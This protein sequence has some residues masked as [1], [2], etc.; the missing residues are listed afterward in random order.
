MA[1]LCFGNLCLCHL[2]SLS[3]LKLRHHYS[4]LEISL[5][6]LTC[7]S[8]SSSSSPYLLC[9]LPIF[10]PHP[11]LRCFTLTKRHTPPPWPGKGTH[12]ALTHLH[13]HHRLPSLH[14]HLGLL[15]AGVWSPEIRTT[16]RPSGTF[17]PN[18]WFEKEE[19]YD[20]Y[21]PGRLRIPPS[22]LQ[23]QSKTCSQAGSP[24]RSI[25]SY[26]S[27]IKYIK[28]LGA[29]SFNEG[30][31]MPILT[32]ETRSRFCFHGYMAGVVK[33]GP[34]S[35]CPMYWEVTWHIKRFPGWFPALELACH[36]DLI[37]T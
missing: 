31:E 20:G 22:S 7:R 15:L 35:C 21:W 30:D 25:V 34:K 19:D 32:F 12:A 29:L 17:L 10:L 6:I 16:L 37:L 36:C 18:G 11:H 8:S 14:C 24:V 2:A 5:Y 26:Q 33:N 9:C 23:Q 27:F 28:S 1:L 3:R 13:H 4:S